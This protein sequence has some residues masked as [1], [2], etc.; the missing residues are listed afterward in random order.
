[1][2]NLICDDLSSSWTSTDIDLNGGQ[3][4]DK[5]KR[6]GYNFASFV[7]ATVSGASHDKS[8]L[9]WTR[10]TAMVEF[11]SDALLHIRDTFDGISADVSKVLT[12]SLMAEGEVNTPVGNIQPLKQVHPQKPSVGDV[13]QMSASMQKFSFTGNHYV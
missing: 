12:W 13:Q 10:H 4:W 11:G 1:M 5:D 9:K 2:H 7:R 8:G 6:S 3:G